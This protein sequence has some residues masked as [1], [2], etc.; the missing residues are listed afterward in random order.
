MLALVVVLA[1]GLLA[2]SCHI[3]SGFSDISFA[4]PSDSLLRL[5]SSRIQRLDLLLV[6]DNSRSMGQNQRLLELALPD[7]VG[8]LINPKCLDENGKPTSNQPSDPFDPCPEDAV[9]AFQPVT[10]MHIG[11]LSSSLG[12]YGADA[13]DESQND[14]AYLITRTSLDGSTPDVESYQDL[15]FLAWDPLG[16]LDPPGTPAGKHDEIIENVRK[17]VLGAGNLGCGYAAPLEAWY[18]FLVD[19]NPYESIELVDGVAQIKGTDELLLAQRKA[20]LRPDSLLGIVMLSDADDCSFRTGGQY[21]QAAQLMTD[22]GGTPYHLAK[23]RAACAIDPNDPCCR[24][25]SQ[26]P[27]PGCDDSLDDCTDLLSPIL[28]AVNVRCFDQKR[29]FGIDFLQPIQRYLD[30]LKAETVADR[31]AVLQPNPLYTDLDPSDSVVQIRDPSRVFLSAIIGVPWQDI[32][33]RDANGNPDL[34][35]GLDAN[36]KPVGGFQTAAELTANNTWTV[37]LGDPATYQQPTDP[38]MVESIEP[39]SGVNPITLDPLQPPDAGPMANPIN[40]HERSIP[41]RDDL[42]YACI[43]P[44]EIPELCTEAVTTCECIAD[45]TDSPLCQDPMTGKFDHTQRYAGAQPGIRYLSVVK[46]LGAQGLVASICP[47][48]HADASA[49]NYGYRQALGS[50]IDRL[51]ESLSERFCIKNNLRA[52]NKGRLPCRLIEARHTKVGA[53]D[54]ATPSRQQLAATDLPLVE[55]LTDDPVNTSHDWNCFC[56]LIQ[57]EGT[58][59]DAC[60]N[61]VDEPTI[62][63]FG[64]LVNGW[65]FVDATRGLGDSSLL[66]SCRDKEQRLIRFVGDGPSSDSTLFLSCGS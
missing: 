4:S 43:Y 11:I 6:I 35:D 22:G 50:I 47:A 7:L 57:T 17:I 32:A 24:S 58:D 26:P 56:E 64:Y 44:L 34:I 36:G 2:A 65:C 18:R 49:A 51:G 48:Q 13:C 42:Q 40:G 28:D 20:F 21:Y 63:K 12:S 38:L 59:L 41:S 16:Q 29:R 46:G 55:E 62:N 19:P 10:D 9:R 52:D 45:N 3:A 60:Q 14:H 1:L 15:G 53:C 33:R 61:V 31:D 66:S 54:C 30:G 25:C 39:R 23:P 5:K 27:G 37:I 8:V